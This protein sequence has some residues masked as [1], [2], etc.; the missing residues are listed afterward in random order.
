[1]KMGKTKHM[2]E[3]PECTSVAI[4]TERGILT[5]STTST[6]MTLTLLDFR[7]SS[8]QDGGDLGSLD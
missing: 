5:E 1:M 8:L 2:Y 7:A 6:V 4:A 3:A